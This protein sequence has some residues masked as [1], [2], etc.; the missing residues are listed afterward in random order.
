MI[1][2]LKL[3]TENKIFEQIFFD[4][5]FRDRFFFARKKSQIFE[6][7]FSK[8]YFFKKSHGN[9]FKIKFLHDEKIFFVRIFFKVQVLEL[10]YPKMK[11]RSESEHSG[12]NDSYKRV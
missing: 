3:N 6:N 1:L 8:K 4:F 12:R 9:F 11:T 5:F 10:S 7:I 2:N